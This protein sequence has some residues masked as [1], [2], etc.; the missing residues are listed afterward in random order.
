ME[1]KFYEF[2]QNNSGGSF[3]V[4]ENVCHRVIIEATSEEDAIIK[5][6]PMILNQSGSCPC[7]G[8]RWDENGA[9][10]I[11]LS[12]WKGKGYE[13][14]VYSHYKDA[15]H[16]WFKLYGHLPRLIEPAWGKS[17]G[18][19]KEFKGK[20]YFD[21]IEQYCQYL[22][23]QYGWTIPDIRIFYADGTNIA[24]FSSKLAHHLN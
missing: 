7:C 23:D 16:R 21:N 22:A 18:G 15:E 24:I 4:D 19:S 2:T 14:G 17:I 5:F 11:P 12:K 13:V 10:E 3:D 9:E 1:T 6:K 20:I 8:D